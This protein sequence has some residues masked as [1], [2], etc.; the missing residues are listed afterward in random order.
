VRYSINQSGNSPS[1]PYGDRFFAGAAP[2]G[3]SE[4]VIYLGQ[5]VQPD[6]DKKAVMVELGCECL[7]EHVDQEESYAKNIIGFAR[8]RNGSDPPS[9]LMEVVRFANTDAAAIS[10]AKSVFEA[11]ELTTV[12]CMDQPG[13]ILNRLIRPKYNAALRFLDEGL[14]TAQ[15]MDLTCKLGLGYP[16]GPIERVTRGGLAYHYQVTNALFE[17]FGASAYAP[18]RRALA[19]AR[20]KTRYAPA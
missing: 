14:A 9:N 10:A 8:Y 12:V 16:E 17:T 7:A 15:D 20:R 13:R 19:A 2:S 1:F 18:P 3:Q 11:A 4:V 5:P 6:P